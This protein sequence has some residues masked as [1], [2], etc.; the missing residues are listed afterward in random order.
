MRIIVSFPTRTQYEEFADI[1][2]TVIARI[3]AVTIHYPQH[4]RWRRLPYLEFPRVSKKMFCVA[5]RFEIYLRVCL[6]LKPG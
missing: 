5:L 4:A 3:T 6:H 1:T 2:G